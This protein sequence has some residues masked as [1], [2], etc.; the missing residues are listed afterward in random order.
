ML[1]GS[2]KTVGTLFSDA[3][4]ITLFCGKFIHDIKCQSLSVYF[5]FSRIYHKTFWLTFVNAV[6]THCPDINVYFG[7]Y[8]IHCIILNANC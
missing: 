4:M 8:N 7:G 3:E 5:T 1:H 2:A 6:C